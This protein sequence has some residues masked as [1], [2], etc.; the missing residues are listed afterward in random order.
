[1]PEPTDIFGKS[2]KLVGQ[3][4]KTKLDLAGGTLTGALVLA[5]QPAADMEA[6]T[7]QYVDTQIGAIN[8]NNITGNLDV[9]GK[10]T[11]A[12]LEVQG[13]TKIVNTTTVEVSDNILELNKSSDGS[14]TN[15]SS[16]IAIN[17]GL[18]A[19]SAGAILFTD[20]TDGLNPQPAIPLWLDSS[21]YYNYGDYD[22][23]NR[24]EITDLNAYLQTIQSTS[25]VFPGIY[26]ANAGAGS[27]A[28]GTILDNK[29]YVRNTEVT[30]GSSAY[31][32]VE[33]WWRGQD[34]G[35]NQPHRWMST[36]IELDSSSA[37]EWEET[38]HALGYTFDAII[39]TNDPDY[40]MGAGTGFTW[41]DGSTSAQWTPNNVTFQ[42]GAAGGESEKAQFLWDNANSRF[43]TKLGSAVSEISTKIA[44]PTGGITINGVDV[45]SY[46]SFEAELNA[47]MA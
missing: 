17:R 44:A 40:E 45:G 23:T 41:Y 30:D 4:L 15:A 19:S 47:A 31:W 7:K 8:V 42:A 27:I 28:D 11:A 2:G 29:Y 33:V 32:V 1:M 37:N 10:I 38:G 13:S 3:K 39:D 6:S 9:T 24:T 46:A 16:G 5:D 25:G 43:E 22:G 26:Y 18:D 36:L 14:S 21:I 20:S 34:S 12:E 35:L